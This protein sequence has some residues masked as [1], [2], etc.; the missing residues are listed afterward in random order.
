MAVVRVHHH[1]GAAFAAA[2]T[3]AEI[4]PAMSLAKDGTAV[5]GELIDEQ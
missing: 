4:G 2:V 5:N 1:M 3:V